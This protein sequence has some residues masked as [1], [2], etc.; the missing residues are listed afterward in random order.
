[1]LL[2]NFVKFNMGIL[3]YPHKHAYQKHLLLHL[4][5]QKVHEN[6]MDTSMH[7]YYKSLYSI[8]VICLLPILIMCLDYCTWLE[9]LT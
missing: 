5:C 7:S 8:L 2:F 6:Q 4:V 1:M 9:S 3:F